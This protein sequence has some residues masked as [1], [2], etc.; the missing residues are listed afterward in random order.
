MAQW[1]S[2]NNA[3]LWRMDCHVLN[4]SL[5][6]VILWE[7]SVQFR[8]EAC[9]TT[10]CSE[11]TSVQKPTSLSIKKW[12]LS[13]FLPVIRFIFFIGKLHGYILRLVVNILIVREPLA[14]QNVSSTLLVEL[15]YNIRKSILSMAISFPGTGSSTLP[16]QHGW[17]GT[18]LFL[19]F[20]VVRLSF[21]MMVVPSILMGLW[22]CPNWSMNC[23]SSS[24]VLRQNTWVFWNRRMCFRRRR[25]WV[26]LLLKQYTPLVLHW[27]LAQ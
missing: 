6:K 2:R 27:L 18:G 19:G 15:W 10:C 24:S 23:K 20:H 12:N 17:C 4:L 25:D 22:Q 9:L 14:N 3:E 7:P 5:A 8:D 1:T 21:S 11:L 13:D 26:L 16:Q